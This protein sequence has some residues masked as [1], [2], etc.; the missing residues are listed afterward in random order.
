MAPPSAADGAGPGIGSKAV[1]EAVKMKLK[2]KRHCY[3]V[4]NNIENR[5]IDK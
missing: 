2:N 1:Y 3:T 5:L 4:D